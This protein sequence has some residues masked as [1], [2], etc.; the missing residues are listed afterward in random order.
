ML[1]DGFIETSVR[2]DSYGRIIS[3]SHLHMF[4]CSLLREPMPP[5]H[6]HGRHDSGIGATSSASSFAG[7]EAPEEQEKS[8]DEEQ[9]DAE[10][11][12][13]L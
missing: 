2:M 5:Q 8:D 3:G 9:P 1:Q 4:R 13:G 11:D 10:P 7:N 12:T 6:I